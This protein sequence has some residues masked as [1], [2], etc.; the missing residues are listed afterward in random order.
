MHAR[1]PGPSGDV[2]DTMAGVRAALALLRPKFRLLAFVPGNHD[3]WLRSEADRAQFP[4]SICRLLALWALCDE[5]GALVVPAEV[6]PGLLL[7]PLLSW[8]SAAFD[9]QGGGQPGRYR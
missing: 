1:A 3:L 9:P 4:D 5:L 2:A 6:A 7:V 8:Y